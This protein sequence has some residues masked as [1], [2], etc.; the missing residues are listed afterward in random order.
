MHSSVRIV[1]TGATDIR[2]VPVCHIILYRVIYKNTVCG[3][4]TVNAQSINSYPNVRL[5]VLLVFSWYPMISGP[6]TPDLPLWSAYVS[7]GLV[8]LWRIHNRICE[9]VK[10]ASSRL[11]LKCA[12]LFIV[13]LTTTVQIVHTS[14]K[15][16]ALYS[17]KPYKF[18]PKY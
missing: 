18:S 2:W 7:L 15:T 5:V 9:R 1:C 12:L 10:E 17:N 13:R 3:T 8:V 14:L 16:I 4:F 6:I 11:I